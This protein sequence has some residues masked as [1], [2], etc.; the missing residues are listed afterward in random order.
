MAHP[1]TATTTSRNGLNI[2]TNSGPRR[3]MHHAI[4]DTANPDPISP[5]N[6]FKNFNFESESKTKIDRYAA[7]LA[8]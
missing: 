4:S 2:D 3:S 5:L 8:N 1:S 7:S 6:K